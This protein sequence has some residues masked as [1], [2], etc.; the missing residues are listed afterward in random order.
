MSGI[1]RIERGYKPNEGT[2]SAERIESS[3][4]RLASRLDMLTDDSLN[5]SQAKAYYEGARHIKENP[6]LYP[7]YKQHTDFIEK[8]IKTYDDSLPPTEAM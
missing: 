8:I 3:L 2:L 7:H 1:D 5:T 6:D 4:K